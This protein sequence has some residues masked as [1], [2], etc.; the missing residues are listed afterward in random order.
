[1][2]MPSS[3]SRAPDVLTDRRLSA[4]FELFSLAT[5][6]SV[7]A[8]SD[9]D[10]DWV[11]LVDPALPDVHRVRLC[12]LIKRR[13]RT[14]VVSHAPSMRPWRDTWIRSRF[15]SPD[16]PLAT[17][18]LD[19]D[20]ALDRE[21]VAG[22]KQQMVIQALLESP[23]Y[24]RIFAFMSPWQWDLCARP[25]APFGTGAPWHRRR[26]DKQLLFCACGLTLLTSGPEYS[27]SVGAV[28]HAAVP[29]IFSHD[30]KFRTKAGHDSRRL[31]RAGARRAGDDWL[32]WTEAT[33]FCALDGLVEP[34]VILN[35]QTNLQASRIT[36]HKPGSF[37]VTPD[38]WPGVGFD[39]DRVARVLHVP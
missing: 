33:H 16:G 21:F 25:D 27:L 36:E 17:V 32:L 5:F 10:F 7:V 4:R 18:L 19:D 6:P 23:P 20:D 15:G 11:L 31:L 9:Q 35:H 3:P 8:Q 37:A 30:V 38:S 14:H 22:L 39:W 12:E 1:M 34:P 28:S 13:P 24:L 2:R 29:D 26:V